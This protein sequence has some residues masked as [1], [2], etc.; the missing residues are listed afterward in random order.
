MVFNIWYKYVF[1]APYK[2]ISKS[3]NNIYIYIYIYIYILPEDL[4]SVNICIYIYILK[5]LLK[6]YNTNFGNEL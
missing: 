5:K 2:K 3:V 1:F 4:E 6:T